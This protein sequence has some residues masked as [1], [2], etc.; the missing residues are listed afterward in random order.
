MS[1]CKQ[2]YNKCLRAMGAPDNLDTSRSD[3]DATG[4]VP[5][6]RLV[7]GKFVRTLHEVILTAFL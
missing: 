6:R 2:V 7:R 5:A 4:A 3:D 1:A